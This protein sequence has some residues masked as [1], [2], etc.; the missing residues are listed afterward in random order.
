MVVVVVVTPLL[1]GVGT[2]FGNEDEPKGEGEEVVP[3]ATLTV[4]PLQLF[5]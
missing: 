5:W 3:L 2:L 1:V 4:R